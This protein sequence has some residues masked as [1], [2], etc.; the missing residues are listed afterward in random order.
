MKVCRDCSAKLGRFNESGYCR[1]CRKKHQCNYCHRTR[2]SIGPG[3]HRCGSCMVAIQ[4]GHKAKRKRGPQGCLV[5]R[6][7][8][9][10]RLLTYEQLAAQ[11]LPLRL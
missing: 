6:P 7:D 10:I 9:Q 11:G 3:A 4:R 2:T 8:V 5:A 1:D